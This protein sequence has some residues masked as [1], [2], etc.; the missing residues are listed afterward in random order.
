MLR[1]HGRRDAAPVATR[2]AVIS[3]ARVAST[4]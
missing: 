2:S 1:Y 4:I 3:R